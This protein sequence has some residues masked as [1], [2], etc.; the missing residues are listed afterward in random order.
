MKNFRAYYNFITGEVM[1]FT[2]WTRKAR[3]E[4]MRKLDLPSHWIDFT[5]KFIAYNEREGE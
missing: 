2:H 5:N 3:N 1:T 4:K